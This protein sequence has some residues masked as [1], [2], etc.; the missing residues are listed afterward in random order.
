MPYFFSNICFEF[1]VRTVIDRFQI[2]IKFSFG[3]S[4]LVWVHGSESVGNLKADLEQREGLP[5]TYFFFLH[6]GKV[7]Q[8]DSRL[9]DYQI[10]KNSTIFV[11]HHLRGGA[12]RKRGPSGSSSYKEAARPKGS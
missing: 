7:L 3:K 9:T 8:E 4:I 11:M 10:C 12:E 5:R 1:G 2:F 6:E